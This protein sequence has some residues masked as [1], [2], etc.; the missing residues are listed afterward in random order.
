MSKASHNKEEAEKQRLIEKENK[1][2]RLEYLK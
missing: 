2:K 1:Q